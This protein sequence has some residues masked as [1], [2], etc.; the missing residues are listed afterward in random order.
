M[1]GLL[2]Q[3]Y[4]LTT[5]GVSLH[6]D[7][8][9][10]PSAPPRIDVEVDLPE[11]VTLQRTISAE[12]LGIPLTLAG[13]DEA[14]SSGPPLRLPSGMH[15]QLREALELSP[16]AEP[17]W[18]EFQRPFGHLPA[19]P[20]ER[21]L[22]P[23][24]GRPLLRLPFSAIPAPPSADPVRIA[25]CSPWP[26]TAPLREFLQVVVPRLPGVQV[27]VFCRDPSA[28]SWAPP[29]A[30]VTVHEL[31]EEEDVDPE[32]VGLSGRPVDEAEL[33]SPWLRWMAQTI[34]P[35]SVDVVHLVCP[36]R[37]SQNF[38]LLDFGA[39]PSGVD[40]PRAIRLVSTGQLLAGLTRLGAWSLSLAMADVRSSG[41]GE[42]GLRIF[43]HR[44]TGLLSGPVTL[45]L[46]SAAHAE[47]LVAA[48]RFLYDPV[49]AP[50]PISPRLTIACHPGL[51]RARA[52]GAPAG[53]PGLARAIE[54]TLDDCTP[55]PHLLRQARHDPAE[56]YA[57]VASSQR[58]L[59]RWTS[60]LVGTETDPDASRTERDGVTSALRFIS[61]VI[62]DAVRDNK[63]AS[64]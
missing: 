8:D 17:V 13:I 47:E 16:S 6:L 54:A 61:S 32:P 20:W 35:D 2:N 52:V 18:L 22:Q 21:L 3:A 34:A 51:V 25:V 58:L 57:W 50:P 24:L 7:P 14:L 62:E 43:G 15:E 11:G 37:L 41:R 9:D 29:G 26:G 49:P 60:G 38:G 45:H 12:E 33:E 40:S 39:S 64:R 42:A 55:D 36:A 1:V 56:A 63:G 53:S 28:V 44:M 31:P 5:I 48:Y 23:D 10:G 4:P 46:P 30:Q 59:E 19:V 27:D